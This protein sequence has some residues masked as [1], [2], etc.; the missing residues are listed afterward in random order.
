MRDSNAKNMALGGVLAALA[1]V[2]MCLG[3]LIPLA[4]YVCP[5]LCTVILYVILR[6]C[7][8]RTA[9]TWYGAV[10]L[11]CLLMAPDKEA[12]GVFLFFGYYPILRS[13][14][15]RLKLRWLF[16]VLYFNLSTAVLYLLLIYVMGMTQLLTEFQE[17][18]LVLGAVTLLLGNVTFLLLDVTLSRMDRKGM[19]R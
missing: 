17:A 7:G 11:L 5:V 2:I 9:W 8:K 3:G 19:G 15:D 1:I 13:V 12:A 6:L 18:G 4:T 16:K 10:S 14:L